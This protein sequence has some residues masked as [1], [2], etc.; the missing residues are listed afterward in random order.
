MAYLSH[1]VE[2]LSIL[3][4]LNIFLLFVAIGVKR[5]IYLGSYF[6]IALSFVPCIFFGKLVLGVVCFYAIDNSAYSYQII[7]YFADVLLPAL[8][9]VTGLL[10]ISKN[11]SKEVL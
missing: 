4:L 5:K 8:L 7:S 9:I 11:S 2:L 3:I 6:A 1:P 10:Y